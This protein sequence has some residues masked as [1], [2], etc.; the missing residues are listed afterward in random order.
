MKR[1]LALLTLLLLP[2]LAQKPVVVATIKPYALLL[3]EVV[4]EKAEAVALV[5]PSANPHIYEPTPSQ[6]RQV[7]AARLVVANGAGLD[8]WIVDKVVRPNAINVPVFT[9]AQAI[10]GPLLTTP[11]GPDPHFWLDPLRVGRALPALAEALAQVDPQGGAVYKANAAR[12]YAELL[13]LDQEVRHLLSERKRP[14]VL[15][16]R[17]PFRYFATQYRVPILYTIVPN[18]DAP[19]ATARAVAEGRK[20]AQENGLRHILAPLPARS[21]ALPLAQNLGMEAVIADVLGEGASSYRDLVRKVALAFQQ[22]LR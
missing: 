20:V 11:S 14:G 21:Q 6:V 3:Q 2:A 19:D 22:A 1:A 13:R 17:N 7:A 4:G 9:M 18:P 10:G 12:L 15:T 16:L 5:P 8:G